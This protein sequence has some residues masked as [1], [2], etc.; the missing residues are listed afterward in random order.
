VIRVGFDNLN[1]HP[2][3]ARDAAFAPAEASRLLRRLD[4]HRTP[5][6]GSWRTRAEIE[7]AVLA[8]PCRDQRLPNH[9]TVPHTMASG[10]TRRR[11][12]KAKV[13]WQLTTSK[14]RRKLKRLY[15]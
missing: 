7:V 9:A 5:Q 13:N 15:P 6:H 1:I 3:A 12:E 14:A 10:P 4:V 2:P 8:T 11:A